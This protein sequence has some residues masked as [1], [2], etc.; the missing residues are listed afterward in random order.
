[1]TIYWKQ[2]KRQHNPFIHEK[3]IEKQNHGFLQKLITQQIL[4]Q[5]SCK[6]YLEQ[7]NLRVE[8]SKARGRFLVTG[9]AI[10]AG[11]TF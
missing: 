4:I 10:P 1:M 3:T 2:S 7:Y 11:I 9:Q 5:M 8:Q 6:E